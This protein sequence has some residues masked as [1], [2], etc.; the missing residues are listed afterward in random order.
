M[1]V[2]V[3]NCTGTLPE[4]DSRGCESIWKHSG[5]VGDPLLLVDSSS[6]SAVDYVD[7]WTMP[8]Y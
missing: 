3:Y 1:S 7:P 2:Y 5:L 4:A 8:G 6:Y